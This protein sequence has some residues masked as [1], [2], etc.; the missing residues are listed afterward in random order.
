MCVGC[1]R[2]LSGRGVA[3]DER[4]A[5]RWTEAAAIQGH[6]E[7]MFN[8]GTLWH[9]G[10]GTPGGRSDPDAARWFR[11]AVSAGWPADGADGD[12]S[13]AGGASESS[14]GGGE[15]GGVGGGFGEGG[16]GGG[17]VNAYG[18]SEAVRNAAANLMA[19]RN[20]GRA[21]DHPLGATGGAGAEA[22][23]ARG[24]QLLLDATTSRK[25]P[26]AGG[27]SSGGGGGG[28]AESLSPLSPLSPFSPSSP[29]L[30]PLLL[31]RS[32]S[33]GVHVSGPAD[34][35]AAAKSLVA[36]AEG[37]RHDNTHNTHASV[38]FT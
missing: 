13:G 35:A 22:H 36:A 10:S 23:F 28:A 38:A 29:S 6:T 24:L 1:G 17:G 19:M 37:V 20:Q 12:A 27:G 31:P 7:A 26:T 34:V 2:F 25:P 3:V 16:R 5:M 8:L 21:L 15:G 4:K 11:L 33:G 18:H 30:T 9:R 32:A 14:S